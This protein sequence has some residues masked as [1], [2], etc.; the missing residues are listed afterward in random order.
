MV[1]ELSA[2]ATI[3]SA[4]DCCHAIVQTIVHIIAKVNER[5]LVVLPKAFPPC[6]DNNRYFPYDNDSGHN[7]KYIYVFTFAL[8]LV[9]V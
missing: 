1:P 9:G 6:K 8:S 5:K 4:N 2:Y 7:V 3:Q